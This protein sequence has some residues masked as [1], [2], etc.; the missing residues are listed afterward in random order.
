MRAE[1]FRQK[2]SESR[3]KKK[4]IILRIIVI[5]ITIISYSSFQSDVERVILVTHRWKCLC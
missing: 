5:I 3:Q 1:P 4:N 2:K